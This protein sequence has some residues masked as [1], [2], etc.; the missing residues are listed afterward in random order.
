MDCKLG[1]GLVFSIGKHKIWSSLGFTLLITAVTFQLYFLICGLWINVN[2]NQ[3]NKTLKWQD[4]LPVYLTDSNNSSIQTYGMTA[5]QAFKCAIANSIA[6]AAIS[7][8][9]GPLEAIIITF[10]GTVLYELNRQLV[11]RYSLDLGGSMTIFC[12][13]GFF[14][15]TIS[16][17]LYH[18][19]QKQTFFKH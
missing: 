11:S 7:G 18:C 19:K 12:F 13:G 8:R 16:L 6:F 5:V 9:A 15:S 4:K 3:A 2:L 10:I 1:F 14:G 17:I